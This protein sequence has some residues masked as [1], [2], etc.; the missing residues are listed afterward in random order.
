MNPKTKSILRDTLLLLAMLSM[1]HNDI[2][3]DPRI[4]NLKRRI[5]RALQPSTAE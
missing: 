1:K 3:I 5:D 4:I 2:S